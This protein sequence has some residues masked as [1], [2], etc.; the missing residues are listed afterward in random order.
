MYK[1]NGFTPRAASALNGA[2]AVAGEFGHTYI[3]TEHLLVALVREGGGAAYTL[4]IQ[5]RITAVRAERA[6]LSLRD[7]GQ[8]LCLGREDVTEH[9]NAAMAAACREA[10]DG[11]FLQAGT[12]HLLLALCEQTD[13]GACRLMERLSLEVKPLIA[14]LR[15]T[16]RLEQCEQSA[17]ERQTPRGTG[18]PDRRSK[19]AV[20]DRFGKDLTD[21][22]RCGRLDPVIG[23]D[24]ETDRLLQILT[25]RTK[26]NP[27]LIGEAGV[28]KTA[29]VEGLAQRIAE[30][31]VPALL[32]DRRV[33]ALDMA[34]L[35]AGTK[36]RGDFEERICS[37]LEEV[38]AS[39]DVILFIDELHTIMGTGAAEG[40]VDAANI[41]KPRLARGDLQVIGATTIAEY[42]KT[43]EKDAALARRFQSILVEE[44]DAPTA[45]AILRGL[46]PYYEKHH[47]IRIAEEAVEA[48]VQCSVRFFPTRFLPDKAIDLLDESAA[49]LHIAAAEQQGRER[50]RHPTL[51]REQVRRTA[52]AMAGLPPEGTDNAGQSLALQWEES[53]RE[54][55]IGQE[56]AV[57]AVTHALM[58]S[59]AGLRDPR[60]PVSSF[61][62]LGPSGVGKTEL[63]RAL[64]RTLFGSEDAIIKLDMSE[65]QEQHTVSRLIGAPPGYVGCEEGGVLT[66]AVKKRPMSVV[67]FDEIEK[68]HPDLCNLLLQILEDG[69]LTD[70]QGRLSVF[71]NTVVILTSNL[72]AEYL[73]R[74]RLLGF[75]QDG[76]AGDAKAAVM[77]V[78]RQRL[79]PEL[80]GR[81]EETVLF[82][83]LGAEELCAIAAKLLGEV[84]DRL[85]EQEITV[86]FDPSVAERLARE[87]KSPEYGARPLR[88]ALRTLVEDPLTEALLAGQL[89]PGDHALCDFSQDRLTLRHDAPFLFSAGCGIIKK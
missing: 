88:R 40:A 66:E 7:R 69:R 64:G 42:R 38:A 43:V 25:R 30:G 4:L 65:Y 54:R 11:G 52:Q 51:T 9:F 55:I 44:P 73:T 57:H 33:I 19:S 10:Q 27:C 8:P 84:A 68:A 35:V 28:G 74:P 80:L 85:K 56:E 26:N 3:G 89:L 47:G 24:R 45:S 61:L 72:G 1:Y 53:L 48:A 67:V 20:L 12:E 23:R 29:I 58:R 83:P 22:A 37:V 31:R 32:A 62:F 17:A 41:M 76:T 77:A 34:A 14:A 50:P 2:F 36:Y 82:H 78:L 70:S 18:R 60:R 46:V 81:I 21:A 79:R 6:L 59:R 13:S 16:I 15:E 63:C 75:S 5:R 87:A 71:S 86:E 49:R 39:G